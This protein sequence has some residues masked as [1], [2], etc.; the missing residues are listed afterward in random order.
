MHIMNMHSHYHRNYRGGKLLL[1]NVA[2]ESHSHRVKWSKYSAGVESIK[3]SCW[4]I[5]IKIILCN[6]VHVNIQYWNEI[7]MNSIGP[8][9][10][11]S[12]VQY[13]T[14]AEWLGIRD[15][16]YHMWYCYLYADRQ[17]LK[18]KSRYYFLTIHK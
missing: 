16:V 2:V 5:W 17:S 1:S 14:I 15:L 6:E 11:H 4:K 12:Q 8:I 10:F 18:Q 3:I 9:C 13:T 7:R